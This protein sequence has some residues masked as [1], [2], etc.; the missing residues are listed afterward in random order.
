MNPPRNVYDFQHRF[1]S[2]S[3]SEG[4]PG[5]GG[6]GGVDLQRSQNTSCVSFLL[7]HSFDSS[8]GRAVDC[9]ITRA[10]IHR[11]LVQ[12]RLEGLFFCQFLE[13]IFICCKYVDEQIYVVL[14]LHSRAGFHKKIFAVFIL[15]LSSCYSQSCLAIGFCAVIA[16]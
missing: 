12:I 14:F 10:D 9:S 16:F 8:V 3:S 4:A 1:F 5:S 2:R 6:G 7:S 13:P 15:V 11:W